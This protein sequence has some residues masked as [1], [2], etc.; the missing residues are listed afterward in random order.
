MRNS[1]VLPFSISDSMRILAF[2]MWW[3]GIFPIVCPLLVLYYV[4]AIFVAR[5]NLLGRIEPGPPTKPL[6]YRFTFVIYLPFHMLLHLILGV[7]LYSD[8]EIDSAFEPLSGFAAG[9]ERF[10]FFT[11]SEKSA[12][13]LICIVAFIY[14]VLV[15]PYLHRAQSIANGVLTPWEVRSSSLVEAIR[16]RLMRTPTPTLFPSPPSPALIPTR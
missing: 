9:F 15:Q 7:G 10:E 12:H 1:A 2:A 11:S 5:T 4:F 3:S 6:Q 13:S 8:V 14:L 16:N